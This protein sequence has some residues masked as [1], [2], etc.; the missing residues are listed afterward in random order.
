MLSI[1]IGRCEYSIYDPDNFFNAIY[2]ESWFEDPLVKQMAEDVDNS[3]VIEPTL[4]RDFS[5]RAM[6][7]QKLSGGVKSLIMLYKEPTVLVNGNSMGENC[8]LG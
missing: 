4:I 3:Q 8:A 6:D 2:E 5:G 1:W 7:P